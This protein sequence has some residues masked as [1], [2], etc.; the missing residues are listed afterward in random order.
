MYTSL[1]VGFLQPDTLG[2]L[3]FIAVVP[4]AVVLIV[5]CFVNFVPFT[6]AKEI[7]AH[8]GDLPRTAMAI[9]WLTLHPHS[10]DIT[11]GV[12]PC[13]ACSACKL[14]PDSKFMRQRRR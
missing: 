9:D 13:Y 14:S 8:T 2:F 6:Q 11:C 1:Y 12:A 10:L 3:I 7:P 5:A 4:T